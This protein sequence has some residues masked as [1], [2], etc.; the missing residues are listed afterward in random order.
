MPLKGH[1]HTKRT[2]LGWAS[3]DRTYVRQSTAE[4]PKAKWHE[5]ADPPGNGSKCIW[6][7]PKE[8]TQTTLR[9]ALPCPP[10]LPNTHTCTHTHTHTYTN[11]HT[12]THTHTQEKS[13]EFKP[14]LKLLLKNLLFK[15]AKYF[16]TLTDDSRENIWYVYCSKKG[17]ICHLHFS[18]THFWVLWSSL[19]EFNLRIIM[20][21][22]K[23]SLK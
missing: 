3:W 16:F 7:F 19:W 12:H 23:R 1:C 10:P 21:G 22:W 8:V 9:K 2:L 4:W 14:S 5:M 13:S 15:W 17:R 20:W 11:T 18:Y 6:S